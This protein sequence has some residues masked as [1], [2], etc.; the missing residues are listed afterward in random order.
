MPDWRDPEAYAYT[1][2]LHVHEWAW[3]FLRRNPDYRAAWEKY[4]V[5]AAKGF[6][7]SWGVTTR[8]GISDPVD[9]AIPAPEGVPDWLETVDSVL[10][11]ITDEEY[12]ERYGDGAP[13]DLKEIFIFDVGR[14]IKPQLEIAAAWL[15]QAQQDALGK[16][17][18]APKVRRDNLV[19]YLRLIDARDQGASIGER[20]RKLFPSVDEPNQRDSA[21][22]ALKTAERMAA[23]DYKRLLLLE[24]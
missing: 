24:S 18:E 11:Q 20:G 1:E 22:S 8:F 7:A 17:L 23:E 13:D 3:E 19:L 9:P 2:G 16:I 12:V 15:R 6:G 4:Q 5:A 10:D 14:P 21:K